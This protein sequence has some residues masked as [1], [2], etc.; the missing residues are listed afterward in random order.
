[1]Y[2]SL[3]TCRRCGK[4]IYKDRREARLIAKRL[5]PGDTLRA[6]VCPAGHWHFGHL[7]QAQK[8]G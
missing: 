8:A 3:G 1:M 7:Q 4:Q 5:F 2:Q 6:Y